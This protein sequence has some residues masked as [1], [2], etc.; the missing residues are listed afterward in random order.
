[1]EVFFFSY[2]MNIFNFVL[3]LL[4]VK[5]IDLRLRSVDRGRK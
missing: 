1:M 3:W 2:M 5:W 4:P